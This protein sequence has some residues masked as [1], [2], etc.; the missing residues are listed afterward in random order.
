MTYVTDDVFDL[1]RMGASA[2]QAGQ[3][4]AAV[5]ALESADAA[6]PGNPAVERLLGL[7]Y[8]RFAALGRAERLLRRAVERDPADVEAIFTLGHTLLRRG[9]PR[10]ALPWLR[11]KRTAVVA[12]ASSRSGRCG[13]GTA[14]SSRTNDCSPPTCAAK[15]VTPDCAGYQRKR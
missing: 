1:Y 12:N 15:H 8:Y 10:E 11:K 13:S 4:R 3:P 7:A 2:L 6:A 9:R 14:S 5:A